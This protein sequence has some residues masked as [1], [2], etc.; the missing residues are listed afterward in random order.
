[1]PIQLQTYSTQN[2]LFE[3]R[4]S[5][6]R[7]ECSVEV[8]LTK[9]QNDILPSLDDKNTVMRSFLDL[10]FSFDIDHHGMLLNR[11]ISRYFHMVLSLHG[12]KRT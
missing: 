2:K 4:Q 7:Y 10:S 1:M 3:P 5:A 8:V 9:V 12:L 6:D 11:L